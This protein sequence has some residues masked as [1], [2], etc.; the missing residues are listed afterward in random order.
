M[1]Y[2]LS[3]PAING[4]VVTEGHAKYCRDNGHMTYKVDGVDQGMCPRCGEITVKPMPSAPVRKAAIDF[5]CAEIS[6]MRL[7]LDPRIEL[8]DLDL[9]IMTQMADAWTERQYGFSIRS[10]FV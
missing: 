4:E 1:N 5:F 2:K 7:R 6:H 9:E 8:S 10:L 3:T